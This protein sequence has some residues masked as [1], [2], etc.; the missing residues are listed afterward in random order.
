MYV[1][2]CDQCGEENRLLKKGYD[3]WGEHIMSYCQYG[4]EDPRSE[5]HPEPSEGFTLLSLSLL[6]STPH[7]DSTWKV[8][9][10]DGAGKEREVVLVRRDDSE[11]T[12]RSAISKC[13]TI[14]ELLKLD[15]RNRITYD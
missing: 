4:C 2:T 13:S 3:R 8:K 10:A 15:L 1:G 12:V 7:Y 11:E 14:A 5:H 6:E 9:Y